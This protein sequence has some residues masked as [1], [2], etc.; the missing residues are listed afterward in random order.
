MQIF[1]RKLWGQWGEIW[2]CS[3]FFTQFYDK[4]KTALK[5]MKIVN[6][7]KEWSTGTCYNM[8]EP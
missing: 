8:D 1:N 4:P 2:E 3:G 7:K 5:K 6:K